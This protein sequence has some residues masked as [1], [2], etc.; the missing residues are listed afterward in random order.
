MASKAELM[1]CG[2][3]AAEANKLGYDPVTN[4]NAA[5][6]TQA[7]AT[8]LTANCSNVTTASA[9][10]GVIIA[11]VNETNFIFNA[12]PNVLTIYPP[13][14]GTILGVAKN[15]GIQIAASKAATI[16]GD[17]LSFIANISA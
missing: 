17:N 11:R 2:M 12:G 13:V 6:S 14:G 1:A 8:S 15:A 3:S 16:S 9:N 5:G 10:Q 7:T 4:F